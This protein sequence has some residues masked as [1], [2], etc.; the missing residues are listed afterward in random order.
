[1]RMLRGGCNSD[2]ESGDSYSGNNGVRVFRD[3]MDGKING[4]TS[5]CVSSGGDVWVY[6]VSFR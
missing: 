6:I 1:M 3:S 4:E 2:S 5:V